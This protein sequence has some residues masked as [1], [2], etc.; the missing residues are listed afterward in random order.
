[1][2]FGIILIFLG[3]A[4]LAD[5]FLIFSFGRMISLLWPMIFL[6]L[7]VWVFVRNTARPMGGILLIGLGG[8][9][10]IRLFTSFSI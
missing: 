6:E 1:M 8:I 4:F 7:G 5:Q 2:I 10:L 9:F 3:I